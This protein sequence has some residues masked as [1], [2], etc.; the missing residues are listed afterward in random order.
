MEEDEIE[1]VLDKAASECT[2]P[3]TVAFLYETTV[4]KY[5][6]MMKFLLICR[7]DPFTTRAGTEIFVGNL[8][9]ELAKQGS[10]LDGNLQKKKQCSIA[11]F[12]MIGVNFRKKSW[13]ARTRD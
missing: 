5:S 6:A 3:T 8:A 11:A 7:G 4:M 10:Q 2:Y 13:S 1:E 12:K 9:R